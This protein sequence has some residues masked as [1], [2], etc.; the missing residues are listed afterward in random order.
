MSVSFDPDEDVNNDNDGNR[1]VWAAVTVL[2]LIVLGYAGWLG[3]AVTGLQQ[4]VAS[5]T[6]KLDIVLADR[7]RE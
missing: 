5:I 2:G 4:Q 6:A 7:R 1:L 3:V